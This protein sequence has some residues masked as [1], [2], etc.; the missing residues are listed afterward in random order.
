MFDFHSHILPDMDDGSRSIE[1]SIS[2]LLE[3]QKH[4]VS[5]IAATPHFY[6]DTMVPDLFLEKRR[7][8]LEHIKTYWQDELLPVFPG[9]EVHY[10]DGISH[11][12]EILKLRIEGTSL[13]LIEMPMMTWTKRMCNELSILNSRKE[14]TVLLAHIERYLPLH[15]LAN[16]ER[17]HCQGILM[18]I[19]GESFL[20]RKTKKMAIQLAKEELMDVL[21]SDC[22]NMQDRPPNLAEVY[23]VIKNKL[24]ET[25]MQ[26]LEEREK[27]ILKI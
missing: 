19:N 8:A 6:A 21:G 10:Y 16:L 17:L 25:Y 11:S 7:K 13:L 27:T 23:E 5:G 22:H 18:Q 2:M 9:A 1:E 3:S 15:N 26:R 4:G 14:I 12:D 20:H 24:G